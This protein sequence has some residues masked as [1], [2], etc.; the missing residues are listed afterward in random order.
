MSQPPF[1]IQRGFKQ[2]GGGMPTHSHHEAQLT[3]AASG[4]V[5]VCTEAGRWLVPS[6][7]AVWIPAG[8]L[9]RVEVLSDAN[10]WMVHW[11]PSVA[12]AWAPPKPLDRTFALRVTPLLRTLFDTAFA[13]DTGPEKT[14]LVVRLMLHELTETAHAP[15]FLPMPTNPICQRVADLALSDC[16]NRLSV[17]ELAS[18]SATSV[19]TLS[20]LFPMETGLTFKSWRQRARI[21]QAMDRLARGKE[22]AR[23]SMEFG[24]SS[25]AAFSS[26]FRQVTAMTPTAFM[27][28]AGAAP[29]AASAA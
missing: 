26:A 10:L 18:R 23:V 6:Q 3:F 22:I 13:A 14:E 17:T 5:Q 11:N 4:M 28:Q 24:F 2:R 1:S 20:R 12:Q 29:E 25:T 8:V 16:Q 21:V 27:S 15:T 9:H 7:L 19:R